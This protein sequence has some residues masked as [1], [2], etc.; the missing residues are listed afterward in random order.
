MYDS[1]ITTEAAAQASPTAPKAGRR[2]VWAVGLIVVIASAAAWQWR[3]PSPAQPPVAAAAPAPALSV[4]AGPATSRM[5]T[6][7][8]R[9]EGSVVA[10]QEL[11]IGAEIGGL[12]IVQAPIEEGM[13]VRAGDLLAALDDSVLAAQAAQAEGSVNEAAAIVELARADLG[14]SEDLVRSQSTSRQVYETRQS[15]TRQAE[16]RL[17]VARARRDEAVAR[18]AQTRILA[19][20]DGTVSRV[21]ARIG[22]V[23]APGQEMF[24]IIRDGRLELDARVPEL[25]LPLVEAG[26]RAVVRHGGRSIAAEVRAVAPVVAADS[27]LG[28]VHIA[29]P[30]DSGLRPGMFARGEIRGGSREVVMV[31]A[32]AVVFRDGAPRAFVLPEGAERVEMRRL[33]AGTRQDGMVEIVEGLAVGERVITAGAGFLADRDLVRLIP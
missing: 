9:G 11:V 10:W 21:S 22:A 6:L 23:S 32:S 31:P 20:T 30:P 27:R 29:L 18:L 13:R 33:T 12:R 14:R 17:L 4:S 8:V 7:T 25:E 19:P 24:R 1:K 2:W 5:L 26:Q 15:A 28:L 3:A 16:A